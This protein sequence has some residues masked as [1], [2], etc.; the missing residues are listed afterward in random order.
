MAARAQIDPADRQFFE[1]IAQ[2]AFCNPFTEERAKLDARLVGHAVDVFS[3][4]HPEE[5]AQA[6]SAR[7]QQLEDK[8]LADVRKY[9]PC[10]RE[11]M[12]TVF[13]F[14]IFHRFCHE[15]DQLI[16]EQLKLGSDSAPLNFAEDILTWLR[17][18]G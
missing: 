14:E 18:R 4:S 13:L 3:E 11:L 12:Q 6:I 1:L 10:D 7:V 16:A 15:L 17:R 2:I 5:L 8:G 9:A